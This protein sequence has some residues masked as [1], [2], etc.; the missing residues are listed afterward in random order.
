MEAVRPYI[1]GK[2]QE[3]IDKVLTLNARVDRLK[4]R[5]P[6]NV[7]IM[8]D[9][10]NMAGILEIISADKGYEIRDVLDKVNKMMSILKK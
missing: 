8:E 10:D 6:G 3:S 7:N 9:F 5:N 2:S 4:N 1:K